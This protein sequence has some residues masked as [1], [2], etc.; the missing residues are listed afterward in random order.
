MRRIIVCVGLCLAFWVPAVGDTVVMKDGKVHRGQVTRDGDRVLIRKAL[1]TIA[2]DGKDV[3]RILRSAAPTSAPVDRPIAPTLT[4]DTA[5]SGPDQFIHPESHVFLT[6]RQLAGTP[7]GTAAYEL[8]EQAKAWRVKVHDRQR[9]F[10]GRWIPPE[11]MARAREEFAARLSGARTVQTKIR[12]AGS[13][14]AAGRAAQARLRRGLGAQFRQAAKVW[15]DVLMKDFLTGIAHLE[16]LNYNGALQMFERCI[17]AAPRVPA[18][19]QG[20]VLALAGRNEKLPALGAALELLGLM[21]DSR[22]TYNLVRK[23]MDDVPGTRMTDP[24]FELAKQILL[25]YEEPAA[26]T[27]SRPGTTWLMPGRPWVAREYTLPTPPYDRLVFRQAVGV[28]V[29]KNALLV[30]KGALR[31]ALEA[32]V[33]I[34]GDVIVPA[35][36]QRTSTWGSKRKV[37]PLDMVM[38]RD[39]NFTPLKADGG[40]RVSKGQVLTAYGLSL[41]EEMGS[42]VRQISTVVEG[43]GA[44]GAVSLSQKLSAGEGVG[45]VVTKDGQLVGFLDAKTDPMVDGGGPDAFIPVAHV[46]TLVK[47]AGR[48]RSSFGGYSRVK[49]TVTPKPAPGRFFLVFI[50]AAEGSSKRRL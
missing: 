46:A 15:P 3:E 32:Y 45:P 36:I 28:P 24:T 29:G 40:A 4:L 49:R 42:E 31:G 16:G 1:A 18:F 37:A 22:E 12:R 10:I 20:K 17:A 23:T 43:L 25:T 41:Y 50:T 9:K 6:L 48:T 47:Q 26:K 39:F 11:D 27:Y 21:P 13:T 2:V 34:R 44:D 33:A 38:V 35:K 8:R 30:D 7:A 14:T 5:R 19:R